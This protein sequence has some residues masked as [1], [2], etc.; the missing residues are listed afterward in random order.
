MRG[1]AHYIQAGYRFE[2]T[3]SQSTAATIKE[4]LNSEMQQNLDFRAEILRLFEQGR[5]EARAV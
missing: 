1:E 3:K 2:K 5:L 4:W